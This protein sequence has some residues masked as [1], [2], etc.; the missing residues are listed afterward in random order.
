[1]VALGLAPADEDDAAWARLLSCRVAE[2]LTGFGSV[3]S[4]RGHVIDVDRDWRVAVCAELAR[5]VYSRDWFSAATRRVVAES[6]GE[7][8]SPGWAQPETGPW[9]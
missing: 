7:C 1:M 4:S 5:A 6:L 2:S 3:W 9:A 8:L